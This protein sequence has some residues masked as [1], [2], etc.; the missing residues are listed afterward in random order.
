MFNQVILD[1]MPYEGLTVKRALSSDK[2][3]MEKLGIT[4][5]PSAYLFHPNGT[6]TVMHVYV[7]HRSWFRFAVII[8][9]ELCWCVI[10]LF[11]ISQKRLRFFFSSFLKLLPGVHRKQSTSSPQHLKPGSKEKG[12][13]VEWKDFTKWVLLY[14]IIIY[15]HII[16]YVVLYT[17]VCDS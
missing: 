17:R 6:H 12:A 8:R 1:L 5:V 9:L 16:A 2:L 4:S 3:L 10:F 7:T 14:Y 15:S 11:V 13:Q